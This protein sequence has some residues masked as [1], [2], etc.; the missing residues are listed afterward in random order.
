MKITASDQ[1]IFTLNCKH[2]KKRR[3][4]GRAENNEMSNIS[5]FQKKIMI[6]IIIIIMII[7]YLAKTKIIK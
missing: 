4:Q 5:S 2:C 6:I 1:S 7:T 3:I